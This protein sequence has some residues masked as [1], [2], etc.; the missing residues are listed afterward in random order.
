L[1]KIAWLSSM[2]M[3]RIT[4]RWPDD[5]VRDLAR[6][7]KEHGVSRSDY[8]ALAVAYKLGREDYRDEIAAIHERLNRI[9][10]RLHR[11]R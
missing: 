5:L 9:E 2:T 3:R 6:A 11:R 4:L 7:A 1:S 8:A 10:D